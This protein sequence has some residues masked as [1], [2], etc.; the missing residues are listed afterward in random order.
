M[1]IFAAYKQTCENLS[2]QYFINYVVVS[3]ASFLFE[4]DLLFEQAKISLFV[5]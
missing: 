3:E 1:C 5:F 4:A 2:Y